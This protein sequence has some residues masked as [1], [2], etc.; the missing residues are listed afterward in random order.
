MKEFKLDETKKIQPGFKV[1]EGY[2]D[3]LSEK[4]NARI[5]NEPKVVPI[6][7]KKTI[8][9]AAA[10]VMVIGLGITFYNALMVRSNA[11]TET[12]ALENYLAVQNNTEEMLVEL[13]EKEDLEKMGADF[14][15]DEKVLE[16]A[17]SHNANLEQYL[18]N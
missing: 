8:W 1:P 4:I 3:R 17:L 15:P 2:F 13:L 7:R 14:A 9:Y 6:S 5:E 10:A 12:V 11:A 18:T 16:E